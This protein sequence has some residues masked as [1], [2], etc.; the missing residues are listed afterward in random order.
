MSALSPAEKAARATHKAQSL[1]DATS[2]VRNDHPYAAPKLLTLP[3]TVREIGL[4]D[5]ERI[6]GYSP[7]GGKNQE[8]LVGPTVLVVPIYIDSV[9]STV[10]MI[11]GAGRKSFLA[12]GKTPG[13][14]WSTSPLP[15]C[16]WTGDLHLLVG[17]GMATVLSASAA[18]GC[19]GVAAMS[20]GNL[21]AVGK[22][23]RARYPEAKITFLAD[24]GIGEKKCAEAARAV[25][26]Y[27][28][29]PDFGGEQ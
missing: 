27:V 20:C 9:L 7:K 23:M 19:I 26:G 15:D 11:D 6:L 12:G 10:E 3:Q 17:E 25:D 18:T 24:L 2:P 5:A 14:Y 13:G 28:A 4:A 1:L 16:D 21:L 22:A 29:I 8:M